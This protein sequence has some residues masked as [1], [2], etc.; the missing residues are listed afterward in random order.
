MKEPLCLHVGFDEPDLFR[1][2][3]A[4]LEIAQRFRIDREDSTGRSILRSHIADRG[5]IRQREIGQARAEELNKLADD[6]L[7]PQNFRHGEH[8]VRGRGP[9]RQ[10]PTEANP[11]NLRDQHG[12]RL[13]E[14][15]GLGLDPPDAPPEHAESV[16]HG[17]VR[18]GA[19]EGIGIG[20]QDPVPVWGAHDHT[21][22]ELQIDLMNN[23]GVGRH[24]PEVG[25]GLLSPT[26]E[27]V[28]LAIALELALGIDQ[29]RARHP[30]GV[31][32]YRVVN[33]QLGGLER[34]DLFRIA[35][36]L[37]HGIAHRREI[38]D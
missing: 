15:R 25:K 21:G 23:P 24:H 9:F 27:R 32:L 2:S 31:H 29:H 19:D 3:A 36:H 37:P 10:M 28:S 5:P 17:R 38:D 12:D 34:I 1:R 18:V 6:P 16:D 26:Q 7:F 33:D 35:P 8:E 4:E 30:K 11:N 13:A 20:Q 14:H 22:Q